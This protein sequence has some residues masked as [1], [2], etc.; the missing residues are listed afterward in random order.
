MTFSTWLQSLLCLKKIKE[1]FCKQVTFVAERVQSET[2]NLWVPV[3]KQ[4]L[5]TW[6]HAVKNVRITT[7]DKVVELREDPFTV[8]TFAG[9]LQIKTRY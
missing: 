7:G 4:I 6:K 3:K 9:S 5:A 8:S 1:D 2:A